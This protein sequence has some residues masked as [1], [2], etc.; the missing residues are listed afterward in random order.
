MS[1]KVYYIDSCI[2]LNLFKKEGDPSKGIPYWKIAEDF[3]EHIEKS[4]DVIV[5]SPVVLKELFFKLEDKYSIAKD[6]FDKCTCINL[7]KLASEDYS[8][9]RKLESELQYQLG[10]FDCLHIAI[11]KRLQITLITRD[12]ELLRVA[13]MHVS[14]Y[15][16]EELI[17]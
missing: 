10:F 9:A 8:F 2:W 5:V 7:I 11:C 17:G 14:A 3:I 12:K 6:F 16:P 4:N 13:K 1:Q 15:R